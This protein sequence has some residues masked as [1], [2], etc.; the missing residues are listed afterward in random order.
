MPLVRQ[1]G[2]DAEC[3]VHWPSSALDE[4]A[5]QVCDVVSQMAF[6]LSLH[7]ATTLAGVHIG[8]RSGGGN[9]STFGMS[10]PTFMSIVVR[11]GG[12]SKPSPGDDSHSFAAT[13][14]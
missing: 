14:Q 9:M 6:A 2:V 11:S 3:V 1:W 7:A 10:G 13:L 8:I 4:Q 12:G 5:R